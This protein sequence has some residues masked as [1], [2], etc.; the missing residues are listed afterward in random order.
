M[1]ATSDPAPERVCIIDGEPL[2]PARLCPAGHDDADRDRFAAEYFMDRCGICGGQLADWQAGEATCENSHTP[3][4][5]AAWADYISGGEDHLPGCQEFADM[6]GEANCTCGG[7]MCDSSF[8]TGPRSDPYGT[9]CEYIRR[10][11]PR[12]PDGQLL[13]RG[14][15]PM[16]DGEYIEW[17]GG[18]YAAGDPLP[19]TIVNHLLP[20]PLLPEGQF[21]YDEVLYDHM[22]DEHGWLMGGFERDD[23]DTLRAL[24]RV[25]LDALASRTAAAR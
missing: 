1:S 25:A 22:A 16:I 4:E 5:L 19:R 13:H 20:C 11:H 7:M 24:H 9:G 17:T 21:V 14:P 12:T 15:D 6:G 8:T 2:T 23:F 10:D 3:D 18:G